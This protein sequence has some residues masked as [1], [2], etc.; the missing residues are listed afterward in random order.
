MNLDAQFDLPCFDVARENLIIATNQVSLVL[1]CTLGTARYMVSFHLSVN[2]NC[3]VSLILE[4]LRFS[5][6]R[7]RTLGRKFGGIYVNARKIMLTI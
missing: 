4:L 6:E 7:A 5:L 3:S 2:F 1:F